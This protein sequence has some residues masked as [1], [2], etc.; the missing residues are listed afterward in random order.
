MQTTLR[1][2]AWVVAQVQQRVQR[3]IRDQDHIAAAPTVSA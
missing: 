2:V 1:N 3:S